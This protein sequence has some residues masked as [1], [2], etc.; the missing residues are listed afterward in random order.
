MHTT[1]KGAKMLE[2]VLS[3]YIAE[4]QSLKEH[5]STPIRLHR[6]TKA[7]NAINLVLASLNELKDN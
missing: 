6:N 2:T 1:C 7:L 4:L 3:K 5:L